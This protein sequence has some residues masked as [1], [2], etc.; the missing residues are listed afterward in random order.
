MTTKVNPGLPR[1]E[2]A[3]EGSTDARLS[4]LVRLLV[5]N[6]MVVVS[7][8]KLADE[9]QTNRSD[10]WRLIEQLRELGVEITGH[11]AT[12]YQLLS[13][14][15]L[16]L[17][18]VI[19]PLVQGTV[20]ASDIRHYFRV[21]STNIEA[22]QAAAA[23]APDGSVFL[24]EEQTAGRGRRGHTWDS[25][26]ST[27]IYCSVVLGPAL[28]P[29]DVLVISLA[30]GLSVADVIQTVTGLKPD[31]RWP[32]DLLIGDRKVCGILTEL[33]A[34]VTRVRYVVVGVGMNVNQPAFP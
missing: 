3:S 12:G 16:L 25:A 21:G 32:N 29:A 13:V 2:P 18:D 19:A 31:L 26:P 22:M 15:D 5:D 7:G 11:S 14:P 10:V 30:A 20:F 6:A 27:G 9:L 4:Q 28:S 33:N 1:S 23:G 17:P 8:T 34:E 24:A